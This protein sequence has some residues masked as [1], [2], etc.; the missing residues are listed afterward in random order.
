MND[1]TIYSVKN[2]IFTIF[3]DTLQNC[4]PACIGKSKKKKKEKCGIRPQLGHRA[5]E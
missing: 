4:G 3:L 2:L 1:H 5:L